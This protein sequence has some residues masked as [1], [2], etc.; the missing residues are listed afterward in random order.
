MILAYHVVLGMYGFWLPNDPRGSWSSFVGSWDLFRFGRATKVETR[1]SVA[2][3]PHDRELRQRAKSALKHPPVRL[4]GEQARAVALGFAKASEESAYPIH[5]CVVLPAHAHLVVGQTE[6]RIGKV[7]GHC[8]ARATQRLRADG[9]WSDESRP[10]WGRRYWKVFLN[11]VQDVDRAVRYVEQNPV[12]EGKPLQRWSFVRPFSRG[13]A[14][15][16]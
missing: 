8:K 11:T 4:T 1:R 12:R 14:T 15:H 16:G 10:V 9:L 7:I 13:S 6:R 3:A 2:N 5:A